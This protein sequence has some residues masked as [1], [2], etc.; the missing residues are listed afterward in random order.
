VNPTAIL[1]VGDLHMAAGHGDPFA[2]DRAF[3]AF[4]RTMAERRDGAGR[5]PRLVVLGDLF[6]L[7]A[8]GDG[9]APR[10]E[11]DALARIERIAAAHKVAIDALAGYAAAGGAIDIVVGNH[12]ADLV[13]PA[14]QARVRGLLDGA[15]T[16]VAFHP[17]IL[18][19]PG[20]LY[21]EHGHQHHDLNAFAT[22]L[23]P[24]QPGGRDQL[25]LPPGAVARHARAAALL[26]R[27]AASPRARARRAAY[28]AEVLRD[29][30]PALGLS[31][32]AL[33]ALDGVTPRG[34][35][36]LA[37]RV[38][39]R[40][41]ADGRHPAAAQRRAAA[42]IHRI[43]E[44]DG[45]AVPCYAFGHTHVAECRPLDAGRTAPVQVNAGT[46]SSLRRGDRPERLAY[47][48]IVAGPAGVAA[49]VVDWAPPRRALTA[50]GR[51]RRP[52]DR[53]RSETA[54]APR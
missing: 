14:V 52:P 21:A 46:W 54:P 45:R 51:S 36:A 17:W 28:R 22:P 37:A 4:L 39:R 26:A 49:R 9:R 7:S 18:Y 29:A 5:P 34:A 31:H 20:V 19:V 10:D 48:E 2:H 8:A 25:A 23:A 42:R 44:A 12:D 32:A 47:V 3:A 50:G 41:T 43:L 13:R 30:A 27:A 35:P 33:C 40:A 6:D 24:W 15:G 1:V 53:D 11:L 38:A 16:A